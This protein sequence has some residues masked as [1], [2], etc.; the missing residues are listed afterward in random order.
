M[1]KGPFYTAEYHG[2]IMGTAHSGMPALGD[3]YGDEKKKEY[4]AM[5]KRQLIEETNARYGFPPAGPSN[6]VRVVS[7][8]L[9]KIIDFSDVA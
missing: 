9:E 2:A 6:P 1:V 5:R 7:H 4:G 8:G 3:P